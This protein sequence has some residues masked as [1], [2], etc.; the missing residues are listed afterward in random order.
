MTEASV[1]PTILPQ[2]NRLRTYLRW[3]V[4]VGIAF[5]AVYP[6]MNWLT[7]LRESPLHLYIDAELAIPF[8]P[9]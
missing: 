1:L 7:S 4:L 2:A 6:A 8:V 3:S 9:Q 5:F